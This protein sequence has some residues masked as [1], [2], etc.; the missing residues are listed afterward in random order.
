M[1]IAGASTGAV[2]VYDAW[3][4]AVIRKLPDMHRTVSTEEFLHT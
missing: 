1:V 2:L 4:L 3:D